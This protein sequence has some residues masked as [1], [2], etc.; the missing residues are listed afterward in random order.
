M[1]PLRL[2]VVVIGWVVCVATM[3]LMLYRLSYKPTWLA[4]LLSVPGAMF[5]ASCA[6]MAW[7]T[8]GFLAGYRAIRKDDR[9]KAVRIVLMF[10]LALTGAGTVV[11]VGLRMATV[12]KSWG[13]ELG[14]MLLLPR[15]WEQVTRRYD[16]V[17]D[18]FDTT[19]NYFVADSL[20]GWTVGAN[21]TSE[22]GL[23][24][25]SQEGLRSPTRGVAYSKQEGSCRVAL[26]GDSFTFG[27]QGPFEETW[28]AYLE[29]RLGSSCRVLNFAVPG[30]SIG[31][32]Y[33][34]YERDVTPWQPDLVVLSFTDGAPERGMGIYCFLMMGNWETCPWA[35]PRFVINHGHLELLNVP[36]L[37]P[38]DIYRH[39]SIYDLPFIS[40]DRWYLPWQWEQPGWNLF[41]YSYLFRFATS[42]YPLHGVPRPEVSDEAMRQVNEAVFRA[43][44]ALTVKNATPY[45]IVYLPGRD[46]YKVPRREPHSHRLLS[47][48]AIDFVDATP[49]LSTVEPGRRFRAVGSHYAPEGERAVADCVLPM[50]RRALSSAHPVQGKREGSTSSEPHQDKRRGSH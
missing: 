22:D 5:V 18:S 15:G 44:I 47:G 10:A 33:L 27:W 41:Y 49:C 35:A 32:M 4:F 36:I 2:L 6:G 29:E 9:R 26:L 31:Q 1:I 24:H 23:W 30:Y 19:P 43:F 11:E 25:S 17:L 46:D 39:Q 37:S 7:A 21:R 38:R 48:M 3:A 20:L 16:R 13:Q 8:K 12:Q 42:R 50:A 40:Y 14:T 45:L 28:G 34:R